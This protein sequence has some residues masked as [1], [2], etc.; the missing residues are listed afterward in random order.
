MFDN[1]N[2]YSNKDLKE[3]FK[4]ISANELNEKTE[5]TNN[6]LDKSNKN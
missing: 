4:N 3:E 2:D 1:L 5:S 6:V